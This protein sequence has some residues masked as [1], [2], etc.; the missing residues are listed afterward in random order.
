MAH[1]AGAAG[2]GRPCI[3]SAILLT[4]V[5]TLTKTHEK[6][7]PHMRFL[8]KVRTC[9]KGSPQASYNPSI[10]LRSLSLSQLGEHVIKDAPCMGRS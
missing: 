10:F 3:H 4:N 5:Y 8:K 1:I 7:V 2:L 9:S 6:M